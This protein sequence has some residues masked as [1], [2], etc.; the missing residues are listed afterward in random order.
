MSLL[1]LSSDVLIIVI[2]E[3]DVKELVALSET[4]QALKTLVYDFGWANHIRLHPRDSYSL[5]KSLRT[6][7]PRSQIRYH[8]LTDKAWASHK[9]A[10]RPLSRPWQGKLQPLLAVNS[11]RLVVAAGHMLYSYVFTI[12]TNENVAPGVQFECSYN[13]ALATNVRR[14]ITGLAFV[15][16]GG[17][18]RTVFVG[19]E[20]G[21]LE[22]IFLPPAKYHQKDVHV[23]LSLRTPFDYHDGALIESLSASGNLLLSLSANGTAGLLDFSSESLTPHML[24]LENRGWSTHLSTHSSSPY[25]AFGT[26]SDTPLVVHPITQSEL[27]PTPSAILRP[28][29]ADEMF[30]SAVYGITG[31]PP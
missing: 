20:H 27:S 24:D 15:P 3:L 8:S 12:S 4:C 14:D 1:S 25:A 23:G 21:A 13:L 30:A 17:L 11:T 9:F 5:V 29:S 26:S 2:N 6:W 16:D 31:T 7:S 19:F 18:D 10:A 28:K 22:K